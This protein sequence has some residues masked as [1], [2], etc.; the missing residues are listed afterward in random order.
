M[1]NIY[2]SLTSVYNRQQNLFKC[3]HNLLKQTLLPKK[4]FIYLSEEKSFLCQGFNNKQI[5]NKNLKK[6]ISNDIFE[7]IWGEDIGPYGKLLP[8][9]KEKWNED[10]VIITF[11]DDTIY[12]F[13]L[14]KNLVQDYHK[15]D[16]VIS[17]RFFTPEINNLKDFTYYGKKINKE[18]NLFNFP[19]GKGGILYHPKFFHHTK[20]LIFRKDFI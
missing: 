3:L 6:I 2:V 18:K 1:T 20:D 13:N 16:C 19:S 4:I 12:D 7:I 11:D 14:I 15:H 9:L 8:V 10:C 17:Y 5:T